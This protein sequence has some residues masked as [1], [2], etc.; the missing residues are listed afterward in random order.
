VNFCRNRQVPQAEGSAWSPTRDFHDASR[1]GTL[2][3]VGG[4]A[5]QS[6]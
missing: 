2:R 3:F 5:R 1:F 4:A 6:D